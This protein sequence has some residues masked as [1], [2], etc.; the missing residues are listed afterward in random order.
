MKLRI[1]RTGSA[2]LVDGNG[3]VMYHSD[4]DHVGAD[5]SAQPAVRRVL[6]RQAGNIRTS[7]FDGADVVASFAPVPGTPWALVTEESWSALIGASRGY[8]RFL[9]LLLALGVAVPVIFVVVGVRRIMRP[10][11]D[12]VAAA[13]QVAAGNFSQPITVRSG[14]EIRELA[15]EFNT[16][17]AALNESHAAMETRVADARLFSA[18][19]SV[20][21]L[22]TTN[23][24]ILERCLDMV[25]DYVAWPIG[26][27]YVA[28]SDATDQL[29]PTNIWHLDN[30]ENFEVFRDVTMRTRFARGVGLPGRVLESGEPAW[31]PNVQKDEHFP[32][33][34]L[35]EDIGVRGLSE[36][37]SGSERK[38]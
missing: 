10:L 24:E 31:I 35:A 1:G 14:D 29:E 23:D 34:K 30:P 26:H 20:S 28:A 17:A 22:Q 4:T 2:Y 25:C 37:L 27:L 33:N 19:A 6:D 21:A 13:R 11:H 32:R 38:P 12:L 15:E 8:Q 9:L 3:R 18:L 16:M 36:F 5:F 7:D